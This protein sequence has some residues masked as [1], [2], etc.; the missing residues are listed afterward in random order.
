MVISKIG[1]ICL[2]KEVFMPYTKNSELPE[3]VTKHLPEHA[4]AIYREA[5]NHAYEEY[6]NPEKR[7]NKNSSLEEVSHRIAWNAVKKKYKKAS[8]GNW[9][10]KE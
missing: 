6:K 8:D 4:Q 2:N 3:S 9:H 10:S 7:R 1:E 5:F